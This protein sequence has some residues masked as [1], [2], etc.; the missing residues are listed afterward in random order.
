MIF[1]RIKFILKQDPANAS[2]PVATLVQDFLSVVI[3]FAIA[4]W[5]LGF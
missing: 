5:V 1:V 3:Y 2:G 4:S